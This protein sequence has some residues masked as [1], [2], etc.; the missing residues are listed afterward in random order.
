MQT[1]YF[2]RKLHLHG[3]KVI[4]VSLIFLSF[5]AQEVQAQ[6]SRDLNLSNYDSRWL[7]YGFYLGVQGFQYTRQYDDVFIYNGDS[8]VAINPKT[9]V[10]PI[11]IGFVANFRLAQYL[12]LRLLPKFSINERKVEYINKDNAGNL[13]EPDVQLI[14]AVNMEFPIL[15]KY[16]SVRRGNYRMYLIAGLNPSIRVGGKKKNDELAEQLKIKD[17]DLTVEVG[18]GLDI[19]YPYFK[20]AP[21]LRFSRGIV[22]NLGSDPNSYSK[23]LN[24][25]TSNSVSLYIYF[26]GGK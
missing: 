5:F 22:N 26:E 21:E 15:F 25:L 23:G 24:R 19:F 1:T 20:F 14:E 12:N 3:I 6:R 17:S 13:L 8:A 18:V 16:K 9:S 7:H 11:N 10:G 2:W 4:L